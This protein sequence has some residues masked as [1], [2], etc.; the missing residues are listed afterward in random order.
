M[1]MFLLPHHRQDGIGSCYP[2]AGSCY[3][4]KKWLNECEWPKCPA[5][6]AIFMILKT[7]CSHYAQK[8]LFHFF[9][10]SMII[11][12]HFILFPFLFSSWSSQATPSN[13]LMA[14]KSLPLVKI[15]KIEG[16]LPQTQAEYAFCFQCQT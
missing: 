9:L 15:G 8:G 3:W 10:G 16:K 12:T 6:L 14:L 1:L 7:L 13:P 2:I 4:R 11:V 5:V